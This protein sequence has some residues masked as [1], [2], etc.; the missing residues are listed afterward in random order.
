MDNICCVLVSSKC[1]TAVFRVTK[2]YPIIQ[3]RA[4]RGQV[5][6]RKP[7]SR[8]DSRTNSFR[9]RVIPR[10]LF[11]LIVRWTLPTHIGKCRFDGVT[12]VFLKLCFS[13]SRARFGT[14]LTLHVLFKWTFVKSFICRS[15]MSLHVKSPLFS[16]YIPGSHRK[17]L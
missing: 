17:V 14:N 16:F 15:T 2:V 1:P 5:R 7:I 4:S 10:P 6:S 12:R 11:P 9:L 8:P 3:T 13:R